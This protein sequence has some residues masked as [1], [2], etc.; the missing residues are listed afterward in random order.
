MSIYGD[1]TTWSQFPWP[2]VVSTPMDKGS[3]LTVVFRS[4]QADGA[5]GLAEPLLDAAFLLLLSAV[6]KRKVAMVL[7]RIAAS[8]GL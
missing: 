3:A 6:Q 8:H 1:W 4:H 5:Q 7:F 2:R